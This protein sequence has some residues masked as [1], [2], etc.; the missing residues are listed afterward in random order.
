VPGPRPPAAAETPA[1]EVPPPGEA[2]AAHEAP[3]GQYSASDPHSVT[4]FGLSVSAAVPVACAW[5]VITAGHRQ[6]QPPAA[7][8]AVYA[9]LRAQLDESAVLLAARLRVISACLAGAGPEEGRWTS[10]A[11]SEGWVVLHGGAVSVACALTELSGVPGR[12]AVAIATSRPGAP[13]PTA[14]PGEY[15]QAA[16]SER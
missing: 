7:I 15:L 13:A 1:G 10:A 6:A 8:A 3:D 5:S 16:L 12:V 4:G 2:T 9:Q 14:N 11:A